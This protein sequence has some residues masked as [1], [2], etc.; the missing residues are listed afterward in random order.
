[1]KFPADS[2]VWIGHFRASEN[3][4]IPALDAGQVVMHPFVAGELACG[5]LRNRIRTLEYFAAMPSAVVAGH[6]ETMEFME[7]FA[8]CGRGIGWIDAHLIVSA[9]LSTCAL[10][11]LDQRLNQA[12]AHAGVWLY[13][14]PAPV[15]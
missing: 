8:L 12:A 9:Q 7:R 13:H 3:R 5:N 4:L 2:S 6:S 15:Q 14:P 10:W 11:S 1:M